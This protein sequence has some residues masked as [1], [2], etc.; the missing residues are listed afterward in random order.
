MT[1][2]GDEYL[3]EDEELRREEEF[4]PPPLRISPATLGRLLVCLWVILCT[5]WITS[6]RANVPLPSLAVRAWVERLLSG[7]AVALP[8]DVNLFDLYGPM[9]G[10]SLLRT[11]GSL[12]SP[13][14]WSRAEI[15]W[16]NIDWLG[17]AEALAAI[18][19]YTAL[20]LLAL[21]AMRIRWPWPTR[22]AVGYALG[23]GV[24]GWV[25]E[26]LAIFFF[27]NRWT[28]LGALV[29]LAAVLG[30][31]WHR[32][33]DEEAVTEPGEPTV[34]KEFAET[35]PDFLFRVVAWAALIAL[36]GLGLWHAV[37]QPPSNWDA[38]I[39]YLGNAQQTHMQGGFPIKVCAQVGVG[40][41]A[42]YPHLFEVTQAAITRLGGHWTPLVG[43]W[44]SPWA[45]L[46]ATVIVFALGHRIFRRRDLALAAA[47]IFRC[48]P[49][50]VYHFQMVS[51][52]PLAI[53]L[54]AA[55]LLSA[56]DW[57][58][59]G[60][61][62]YAVL[63]LALVAF[64]C[65][66]NYLMP[67]MWGVAMLALIFRALF[68]RT[69]PQSGKRKGRFPTE[70][71][72]W[73]GV[74]IALLIALLLSSTWYIRNIVVTGNPV[75]A[76]FHEILGG[77][78]INPDVLASAE[79]EWRANG[80][81][82][83]QQSTLANLGHL[84]RYLLI[85][86]RTRW[87]LSPAF[88]GFAL[89][90]L[91]MLLIGLAVWRRREFIASPERALWWLLALSV[92]GGLW[93]YHIA[94]ADYYLYQ[95]LP[96]L[97]PAALLATLPLALPGVWGAMPRGAVLT[98]ALLISV[99]MS[100][101][102]FKLR[103]DIEDQLTLRALTHPFPD[104]DEYYARVYPSDEILIWQLLE[105]QWQGAR[106]LTHDN[107]HLIYDPLVEI[108][109]LDDWE[110]QPIYDITSNRQR[111]AFWRDRGVDLYLRIPN[112]A[113]HA[114]NAWAGVSPLIARGDLRLLLRTGN[115]D[116]GFCALYAF[117]WAEPR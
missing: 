21:G 7:P 80:D 13:S 49:Y 100:L 45:A 34:G 20:G 27:L 97:V 35:M 58:N 14:V 76:F 25:F 88:E 36:V 87:L 96:M 54:T 6:E 95:I 44:A 26:G 40:L 50:S 28:V 31:F 73:G 1:E 51:N 102:G 105:E 56:Y 107:R 65:H 18:A 85:D 47:L 4:E 104:R 38:L 24:A 3:E 16:G 108:V 53:L 33:R 111:L 62:R 93:L 17:H 41:G 37:T 110:V 74:A 89:P 30:W 115:P 83:G 91:L 55:M 94:L 84:P 70:E 12:L 69:H 46:C 9:W 75:Y 101:M 52:Y 98:A 61:R 79:V 90:G 59:T 78:H 10:F 15:G 32:A 92:F 86:P 67:A 72:R 39:L 22:L 19:I 109:H 60:H 106:L 82:L 48:I 112:E 8:S 68:E 117:P 23:V 77:E 29:L 99:P 116:D 11:Y 64:G 103:S 42:N 81:G 71:R 57:L 5:L 66:I 63:M 113:K 2:N 43:Q 114:A